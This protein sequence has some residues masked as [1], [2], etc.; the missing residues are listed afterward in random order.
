M[1]NYGCCFDFLENLPATL[2]GISVHLDN[3][4]G[5]KWPRWEIAR[6]HQGVTKV[7][8][9]GQMD[10]NV[11]A[12]FVR[13]FPRVEAFEGTRWNLEID[14]ILSGWNIKSLAQTE[15]FPID[16]SDAIHYHQ[17]STHNDNR[18]MHIQT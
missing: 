16:V 11:L 15:G 1:S 9:A 12:K 7:V 17:L 18:R 4:D 6:P 5:S 10:E 8:I 3:L 14:A 2:A 13:L